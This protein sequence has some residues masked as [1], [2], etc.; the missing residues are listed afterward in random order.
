MISRQ[1]NH[2]DVQKVYEA[3]SKQ[4][5]FSPYLIDLAIHVPTTITFS[6]P[7]GRDTEDL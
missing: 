5:R 7:V 6:H 3:M 2:Y 4:R 1:T